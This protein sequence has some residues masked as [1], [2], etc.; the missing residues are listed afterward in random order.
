MISNNKTENRF[1]LEINYKTYFRIFFKLK[2]DKFPDEFYNKSDLTNRISMISG[3][4]SSEYYKILNPEIIFEKC[5]QSLKETSAKYSN[6]I[7]TALKNLTIFCKYFQNF[8]LPSFEIWQLICV[9]LESP[10]SGTRER[11]IILLNEI[12]KKDFK[13]TKKLFNEVNNYL[14]WTNKNKYFILSSIFGIWN[15][16][17]FVP[18]SERQMFFHGCSISLKHKNL[19]SPGQML[20]RVLA[21]NQISGLND[22]IFLILKNGNDFE[23]ENCVKQWINS[24]QDR[25]DLF[26]VLEEN[27]DEFDSERLIHLRNTMK[28]CFEKSENVE[29]IDEKLNENIS[30]IQNKEE[31][32]EFFL[33]ISMKYTKNLKQNL[34]ALKS[35]L[36]SN[37]DSERTSLRQL[38]LKK[39]SIFFDFLAKAHSST[40]IGIVEKQSII[41]FMIF[42]KTDLYENGINDENYQSIIF[43]LKI[44]QILLKAFSGLNEKRLN[45]NT[46]LL[47]NKKFYKFLLKNQI[48]DFQSELHFNQMTQLLNNDFDDI[49]EISCEILI[50]YF[51]KEMSS[52][53]ITKTIKTSTE[54]LDIK[55]CSYG[56]HYTKVLVSNSIELIEFYKNLENKL[57]ENFQEFQKDPNLSIKKT[58]HLFGYLNSIKEIYKKENLSIDFLRFTG[59][60]ILLVEK[61][62]LHL[63]EI[64]NSAGDCRE[65]PNFEIMYKSLEIFIQKSNFMSLNL[66]EDINYLLVSI[67]MTLKVGSSCF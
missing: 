33:N 52:E 61:I 31:V 2:N 26:K 62:S 50:N 43:S 21:K 19:L 56:H 12:L 30:W 13:F 23:F 63:L 22:F 45:K 54:S 57:N 38:I 51:Q 46:N 1:L 11:G 28:S 4:F 8:D 66:H 35:F 55:T 16:N 10:F 15:F 32:F 36:K 9:N 20:I 24:I 17:E 37:S 18:E 65:S 25:E 14:P 53:K 27:F 60:L 42:L 34:E 41:D 7:T 59:D 67:W 39:I 6:C 3:I 44:Y 47:A 29:K 40:T 5:F 58:G 49:R 48:W 64:L